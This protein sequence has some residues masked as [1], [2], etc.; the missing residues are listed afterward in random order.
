MQW[1]PLLEKNLR[2]FQTLESEALKEAIHDVCVEYFDEGRHEI[3]IQHPTIWEKVLVQWAQELSLNNEQYMLWAYK[4]SNYK[5]VH[6]LVGADT[7]YLLDEIL[8]FNPEHFEVKKLLLLHH[9]DLLDFALHELPIGVLLDDSVCMESIKCCESLIAG[10]PELADSQN[11]FGSRFNQYKELYLAWK[12]Y[13]A[14][15]ISEEFFSWFEKN[16]HNKS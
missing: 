1:K 5:G 3:P 15:K 11:R 9:V 4:A 14:T 13:K 10:T 2:C 7:S 6:K 8:K 12:E 16:Y